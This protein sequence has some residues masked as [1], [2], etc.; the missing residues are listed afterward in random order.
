MHI[1]FGGSKARVTPT[2]GNHSIARLELL[3]AVTAVKLALQIQRALD[4]EL[5]LEIFFWTDSM[6]VLYWI[7][8]EWILWKEWVSNRS[9]FIQDNSAR[10]QW[11]HIAGVENPADICSRGMTLSKLVQSDCIWFSGPVFLKKP[12]DQWPRS[13]LNNN[14]M[15]RED[16]ATEAKR[17]TAVLV[18]TQRT[19]MATIFNIKRFGT[20]EGAVRCTAQ[21]QRMFANAIAIGQDQPTR[22]GE[23]T[24]N[25]LNLARHYWYRQLQGEAFAEEREALEHGEN[26]S[27]S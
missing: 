5:E 9:R 14:I 12:R 2:A 27:R 3:G 8:G 24:S 6:V 4:P 23:L 7:N 11:R 13:S 26:V 21:I 25:D 19:S 10:S 15:Q 22:D 18:S 16:V 17:P 20:M 1:A